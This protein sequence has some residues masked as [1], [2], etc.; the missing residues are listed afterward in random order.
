[1]TANSTSGIQAAY[2]NHTRL[3]Q[4]IQDQVTN[5]YTPI[6]A[7][8]SPVAFSRPQSLLYRDH[9][10]NVMKVDVPDLIVGECGC[11]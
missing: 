9:R 7:C 3:M 8:C 4:T 2:Y 11:T 6:Q 1:M 5:D 10:G